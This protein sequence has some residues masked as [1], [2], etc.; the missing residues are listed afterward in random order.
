MMGLEVNL[1]IDLFRKRKRKR[2]KIWSKKMARFLK[3]LEDLILE[4]EKWGIEDLI[5]TASF[6]SERKERQ[7]L[8]I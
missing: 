7:G 5:V 3:I 8:G 4:R 2:E 1:L 6:Q